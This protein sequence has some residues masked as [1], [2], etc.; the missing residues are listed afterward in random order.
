[1]HT[2]L[3]ARS[4]AAIAF[5]LSLAACG[6]GGGDDPAPSPN[7]EEPGP[8]PDPD[9]NPDPDPDPQPQAI[10]GVIVVPDGAQAADPAARARVKAALLRPKAV[11][12]A[13][14]CAHIPTGYV[15]VANAS[16]S[17]ST[18]DGQVSGVTAQTDECGE[19]SASVPGDIAYVTA[20]ANGYKDIKVPVASFEP[21]TGGTPPAF[22]VLPDVAGAGYEI[23]SLQWTN[24]K[25][26]F[27]LV[28]T[29]TNKAVLGVPQTA[30]TYKVNG[31]PISDLK[32][33]SYAA[34]QSGGDAS[35][36]LALD[37]SGSMGSTIYDENFNPVLDENGMRLNAL[38]MSAKASHTFLDGKRANDEVGF[39]IFDGKTDWI[40][41]DYLDQRS[42][43]T[44]P[45]NATVPYQPSYEASGF[46]T[47]ANDLRLTVD[48][49]NSNSQ[50]WSS[51]GADPV[52]SALPDTLKAQGSYPWGG[53]TAA[54]DAADLARQ[55][56]EARANARKI[57]VLMS[58]GEDN[59][60]W[61]VNVNT[62]IDNFKVSGIP[63]WTVA[64]G[65][66]VSEATLKRIAD[67]TGGHYISSVDQSQLQAEFAAM[68]TGIVFQYIAELN[69]DTLPAN[70][71]LE[72]ELDY[73]SLSTSRSVTLQ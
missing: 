71:T 10:Q 66:S 30:V 32:S 27:T 9:P 5:A 1:M 25:L 58:D 69:E 12:A 49:Y 17:F 44:G 45:S 70:T 53:I 51:A 41:S 63:L 72:L 26:Y 62:L 67:E 73:G 47:S 50:L 56:V 31:G 64:Y 8:G 68:Q 20:S 18:A 23:A 65:A 37:A 39:V 59:A 16:I 14:A 19:F 61:N 11:A 48:F 42:F 6:G 34:S 15:P 46:N 3:S 4:L 38:R 35:I 54:Y 24:S 7:P 2:V 55:K 33:L 36:A 13:D 57:V 43:V 28:D 60:S 29:I 52:H 22:S 21:A 40:D